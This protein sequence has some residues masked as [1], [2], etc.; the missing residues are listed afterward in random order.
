MFK[1][2][3]VGC[4]KIAGANDIFGSM[5]HGGAYASQSNIDLVAAVD[6]DS[7][8]ARQF[9]ELYSCAYMPTIIFWNPEYWHLHES[10]ASIFE[11][12]RAVGIFHTSPE[13]AAHHLINIWDDVGS[14]WKSSEVQDVRKLYC[15]D[16]ANIVD[17]LPKVI[18]NILNNV[19]P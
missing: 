15:K 14:W 17:N 1:A 12:L 8:K 13:S 7:I 3:I 16:Y 4:G 18:G 6:R 19:A 2:L 11:K 10:C 9:A 5:T